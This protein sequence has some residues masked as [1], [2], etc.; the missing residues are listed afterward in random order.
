LIIYFATSLVNKDELNIFH[1][2]TVVT[3]KPLLYE[4]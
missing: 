3:Q 4:M 1:S 2:A